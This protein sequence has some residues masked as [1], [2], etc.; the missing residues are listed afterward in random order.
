MIYSMIA[1]IEKSNQLFYYFKD[2]EAAAA[3]LFRISAPH[4]RA[5]INYNS[6]LI[7]IFI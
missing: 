4:K 1:L 6:S 7:F 3:T 5:C 2:A